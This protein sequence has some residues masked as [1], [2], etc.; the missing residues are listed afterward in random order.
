MRRGEIVHRGIDGEEISIRTWF[1]EIHLHPIRR[2][3][4]RTIY[5]GTEYQ[6]LN[7]LFGGIW[8]VV[9]SAVKLRDGT[10]REPARE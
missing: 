2:P 6:S 4:A 8:Y 10:H 5:K 1:D 3:N 9:K 7:M